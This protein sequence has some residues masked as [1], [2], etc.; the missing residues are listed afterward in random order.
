MVETLDLWA[1]DQI[2][3]VKAVATEPRVRE[4]LT[5]LLTGRPT[6]IEPWVKPASAIRGYAGYLVTDSEWRVVASDRPELLGQPA[7][8]A[9]DP[10]FTGRLRS[11]GAAITRPLPSL[12]PRL[13]A[14]GVVRA[15]APTQFVCAW[16]APAGSPGGALCFRVDRLPR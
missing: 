15:G 14:K 11:E 4:S 16:V 12:T 5:A 8:F 2:G 10:A 1:A 13:D 6:E 7:H 3:G 9:S